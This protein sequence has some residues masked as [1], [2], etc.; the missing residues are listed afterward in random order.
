MTEDSLVFKMRKKIDIKYSEF[1]SILKFCKA[2][3]H[4]D[5]VME[6]WRE[7]A[8]VNYGEKG[9]EPNP[10]LWFDTYTAAID[11]AEG[12]SAVVGLFRHLGVA[13]GYLYKSQR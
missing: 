5:M 7:G 13:Q 9:E 1:S 6:F 3:E 11:A 12:G 2:S 10:R 8:L 4:F